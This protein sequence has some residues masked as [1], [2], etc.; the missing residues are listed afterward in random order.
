[1]HLYPHELSGGMRQRVAIAQAL[2]LKPAILLLDEPFGALDEA[3]REDLQQMLLTLYSDNQTAVA[4]GEQPLYTIL[5]VTHELHEAIYISDRVIGL[6]QYWDWKGAGHTSFPGATVVYDHLAPVFHPDDERDFLAFR[7][8]KAEI[9][10]T[11][12]DPEHLQAR[13]KWRQFWKQV[14]SSSGHGVLQTGEN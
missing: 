14:N 4:K 2:I 3:T 8:Q 7:Q 1:M 6:S 9:L 11:T 12:F 10:R 5:M 13:E